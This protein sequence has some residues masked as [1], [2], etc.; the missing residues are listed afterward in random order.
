MKFCEGASGDGKQQN[1]WREN[2]FSLKRDAS[3]MFRQQGGQRVL[4]VT[5][6]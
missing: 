4:A 3:E 2:R 6:V 1:G 5:E